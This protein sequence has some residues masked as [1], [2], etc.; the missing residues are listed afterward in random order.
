MTMSTTILT[1]I[2][3][4]T[5][6]TMT[7]QMFFCLFPFSSKCCQFPKCTHGWPCSLPLDYCHPY[8]QPA[9]DEWSGRTAT[10]QP[11]ISIASTWAATSWY[12]S[13]QGQ[14]KTFIPIHTLHFFTPLRTISCSFSLLLRIQVPDVRSVG[15]WRDTVVEWYR[16]YCSHFPNTTKRIIPKC[17]RLRI[18]CGSPSTL[19][20]LVPGSSGTTAD[21]TVAT[22]LAAHHA[23][24]NVQYCFHD[25]RKTSLFV[26]HVGASCAKGYRVTF[27]T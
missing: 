7:T 24:V 15:G 3:M 1:T 19:L 8:L 20:R 13:S 6:M 2:L 4:T 27:Y 22:R 26:A 9:N 12:F 23:S 11:W 16:N 14:T 17:S 5:L 25:G 10:V 18:G 21:R